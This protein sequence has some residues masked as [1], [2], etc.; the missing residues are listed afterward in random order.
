MPRRKK[1]QKKIKGVAGASG[2]SFTGCGKTP[3]LSFRGQVLPEESVFL[4]AFVKKQI[5][6]CARDDNKTYL[7]R[8]L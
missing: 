2:T 8:S 3:K 4:L 1:S 5:P 6:H 7:F